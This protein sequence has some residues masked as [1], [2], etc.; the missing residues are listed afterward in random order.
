MATK[1]TENKLSVK[2]LAGYVVIEPAEAETKTASGIYL[3]EN[4]TSDKP[5]KG[6]VIAI[7]ADEILESGKSKS[8]PVKIGDVVIYKKWGGSEVK[9]SGK[10]Y[11]F[12][13]FDDLLA[14]IN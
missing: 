6:K 1:T 12:A 2:P 14:V 8:C 3:P 7:G 4:A 9:V 13:K 5:Q 10:E 11:L